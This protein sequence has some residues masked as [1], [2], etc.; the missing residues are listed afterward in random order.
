MAFVKKIFKGKANGNK[1]GT[2]YQLINLF[3]FHWCYVLHK[4]FIPPLLVANG[5]ESSS[6]EKDLVAQ[7][8]ALSVRDDGAE[9]ATFAL[10]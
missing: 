1:P 6:G 10:S 7:T 4:P 9:V 3:L 2:D 5:V 8:A